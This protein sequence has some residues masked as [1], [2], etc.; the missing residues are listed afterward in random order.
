MSGE[1]KSDLICKWIRVKHHHLHH[2]NLTSDEMSVMS[3][4]P[5]RVEM[6]K[7][8]QKVHSCI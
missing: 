4:N 5:V 2:L 8:I 6:M 7:L 3:H 1:M